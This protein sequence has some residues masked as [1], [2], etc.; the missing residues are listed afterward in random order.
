MKRMRPAVVFVVVLAGA[1]VVPTK[2]ADDPL[3]NLL[4]LPL[5]PDFAPIRNAVTGVLQNTVEGV[6]NPGSQS[7]RGAQPSQNTGADTPTAAAVIEKSTAKTGASPAE[8]SDPKSNA[9]EESYILD[10]V[11]QALKD[12]PS[13]ATKQAFAK[14]K[15]KPGWKGGTS[16]R[17]RQ[18][19]CTISCCA[20]KCGKW[21]RRC[22]AHQ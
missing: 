3:P 6:R 21:Q 20:Q 11:S 10:A 16:I 1:G 15:P 13:P 18:G 14:K 22:T 17:I 5:D 2:A 9:D 4:N 7:S 12:S 19:S 8:S